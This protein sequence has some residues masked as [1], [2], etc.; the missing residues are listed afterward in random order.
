M[1]PN[2]YVGT[3]Q[4]IDSGPPMA[5]SKSELVWAA[6]DLPQWKRLHE[7]CYLE[8]LHIVCV[9]YGLLKVY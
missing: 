6:G 5:I 3:N 1:L 4:G 8:C 2:M 7:V 9:T